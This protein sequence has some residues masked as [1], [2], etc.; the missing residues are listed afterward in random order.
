MSIPYFQDITECRLSDAYDHE[1]PLDLDL[2]RFN[3]HRLANQQLLLTKR[4][5]INN[6][7]KSDIDYSYCLSIK[8][9]LFR[10]IA[11]MKLIINENKSLL[12]T[13]SRPLKL[14]IS[15]AQK[16]F[17]YLNSNEIWSL[18]CKNTNCNNTFYQ[19]LD[20]SNETIFGFQP[21][22]GECYTKFKILLW[23]C[24][25]DY[26]QVDIHTLPSISHYNNNIEDLN[27]FSINFS[28]SSVQLFSIV[29][30]RNLNNYSFQLLSNNNQLELLI[31][32]LVEN[33]IIQYQGQYIKTEQFTKKHLQILANS[34]ID[35]NH[36]ITNNQYPHGL[37][38]SSDESLFI[39]LMGTDHF[40]IISSSTTLNVSNVCKK[41]NTYL[42]FIDNYLNQEKYSFAFHSKFAYLTSN[43]RELS[44]FLIIIHC[45]IFNGYYK[46]LLENQLEKF[47]KYLIYSIN[48]FESSTIIIR[49]Q[50]L[51]GLNEN[52]KLLRTIYAFLIVLNNM[53]EKLSNVQLVK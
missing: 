50:H 28:H 39:W 5:S 48:P 16:Y 13:I 47:Q 26:Y 15:L 27:K 41:L 7:D 37:Y 43:I 42:M 23:P 44:G 8:N 22:D 21:L 52:E 12:K 36:T 45:R 53:K 51:L 9:D 34:M 31:N 35:N 6:W 11:L 19:C 25:M 32:K 10:E 4:S 49:N 3:A 14:K 1:P 46:K 20:Q 18:M 38:I 29:A 17:L 30:I 2:V 24:I 33:I 40:R